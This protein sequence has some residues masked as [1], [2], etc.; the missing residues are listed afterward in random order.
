MEY[1][2]NWKINKKIISELI[3]DISKIY[4]LLCIFFKKH[5]F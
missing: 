1:D 3:L 2:F 5:L 4:N